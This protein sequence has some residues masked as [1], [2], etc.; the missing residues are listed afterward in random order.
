MLSATIFPFGIRESS[1]SAFETT[2]IG[3]AI[4]RQSDDR[5][6]WFYGKPTTVSHLQLFEGDRLCV[7][8]CR[9]HRF[10]VSTSFRSRTFSTAVFCRHVRQLSA[11]AKARF[12]LFLG[13]APFSLY[14][15]TFRTF[16]ETMLYTHVR[17][18]FTPA[19]VCLLLGSAPF[20]LYGC[21]F[22]ETVFCS[23]GR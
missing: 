15:S 22:S 13:S 10:N 7:G 5:H 16:P 4:P 18:I 2:V 17:Q 23:H 11:P 3:I 1:R 19:E 6:C 8:H 12:C 14:C 21:K 20:P 9:Q